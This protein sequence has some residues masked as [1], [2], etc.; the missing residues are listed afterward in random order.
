M[1][2]MTTGDAAALIRPLLTLPANQLVLSSSAPWTLTIRATTW[3]LQQVKA[4]LAPYEGA[5][6]PSCPVRP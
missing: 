6:A 1:R 3:Q 4:A 2:C 5:G